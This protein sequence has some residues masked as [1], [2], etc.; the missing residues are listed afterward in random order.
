MIGNHRNPGLYALAAQDIF[1][2]LEASPSR[3]E[4]VVLISFYEIYCGHLYD[5]LNGRQR[6]DFLQACGCESVG[7]CL[8]ISY[9]F[10]VITF[11]ILAFI[12]NV[13]YLIRVVHRRYLRRIARSDSR[14]CDI[15]RD[16]WF[17]VRGEN[18]RT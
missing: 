14:Y 2:Y 17:V 9:C 3:N 7:Y 4:Q 10:H 18:I 8:E 5:L 16:S 6:Y 11:D 15:D 12:V 13:L 1:R